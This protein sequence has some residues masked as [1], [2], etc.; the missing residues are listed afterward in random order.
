MLPEYGGLSCG[1]LLAALT[2][3]GG[4]ADLL[5]GQIHDSAHTA[6]MKITR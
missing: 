2:E 1:F 6:L 4:K 3:P 5:D